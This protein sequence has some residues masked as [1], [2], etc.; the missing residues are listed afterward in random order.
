M[1]Q[2]C[3]ASTRKPY[4][5]QR[6]C[7]LW[8]V[9]RSTVYHRQKAVPPP[10]SPPRARRRPGPRGACLD[11]VLLSRIRQ[12]LEDRPFVGEGYRKVWALL[13]HQGLRVGHERV[14]R[15]MREHQLLAPQRVR[16]VR[17]P[18][19]HDRSIIPDRPHTLWGT[20]MT[21]TVIGEGQASVFVAIDHATAQCVGLHAAA[22]GTRHEALEPIRQGMTQCFGGLAPQAARG[23]SLRHD[24]GS[25]YMSRDFQGELSF[26]GI[27]S[28]PSFVREPQG[29][30]C[31]ERFIRTLKEN[32]LW[33]RRFDTVEELRQALMAFKDTYNQHWRLQRLGYRTPNQA[34]D[35]AA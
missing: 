14:L 24:H 30:G 16:R 13:R 29:N 33:I 15:L 4:G 19:A 12:V 2:A 5:L 27:R 20:D 9:P 25:Q 32:L 10:Q 34:A 7:R 8:R 11:S 28:S 26:L 18:Q 17:G 6:V 1:S 23:L 21:T 35:V 3:S 22:R 31:A